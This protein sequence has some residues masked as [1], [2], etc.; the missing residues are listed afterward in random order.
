[1]PKSDVKQP[2]TYVLNTPID[3]DC[4]EGKNDQPI[5]L[6]GYLKRGLCILKNCPNEIQ[7][8]AIFEILPN[9]KLPAALP[10]CPNWPIPY[11]VPYNGP[12]HRRNRLLALPKGGISF[13][14]TQY[15]SFRLFFPVSF[16]LMTKCDWKE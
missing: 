11:K 16:T 14:V 1:M 10:A 3:K 8:L 9:A 6:L 15:L 13:Q 12:T 5:L 4:S 7:W 2:S